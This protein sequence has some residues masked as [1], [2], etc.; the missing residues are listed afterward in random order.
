MTLCC[1]NVSVSYGHHKALNGFSISLEAGEIRALVGPNGSGKS[2]A[3]HALAGLLTPDT[4]RV[5]IDGRSIHDMKRRQLARTLAFLPQQPSAPE[6]MTVRQLV[7]QGRFAHVGLL[8]SYG[9]EDE[10]AVRW[11]LAGTGLDGM[12]ERRLR[13][14]SGG[15]R[16]RAWIAAALAQEA[17]I[18]LLDEPTSFLDIGHQVEVLDLLHRLSIE[19]KTTIVMAIHDLNQAM[20][21]S[22]YLSLLDRGACLFDGPPSE[23][24]A[25]GLIESTFRVSGRFVEIDHRPHFDIDLACRRRTVPRP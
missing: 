6:E 3:L 24:A 13:D 14:I 10:E 1:S 4:G 20:S 17:S 9:R 19:R 11:A 15:E 16:Q 8:R 2:T 23:L 7:Y 25:S 18:L 21:I 5:E 22:D 12:A